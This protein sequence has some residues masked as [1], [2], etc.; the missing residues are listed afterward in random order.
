VAKTLEEGMQ[1]ALEAHISVDWTAVGRSDHVLDIGKSSVQV[2]I[3]DIIRQCQVLKYS[4]RYGEV[5][6]IPSGIRSRGRIVW[7]LASATCA[8]PTLVSGF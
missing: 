3:D 5:R 6:S 4:K 1:A 8:V 7:S 2:K